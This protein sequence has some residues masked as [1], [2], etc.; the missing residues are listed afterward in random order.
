MKNCIVC[1]APLPLRRQKL[2]S[3]QCHNKRVMASEA[4]RKAKAKSESSPAAKARKRAREEAAKVLRCCE[5]CGQAWKVK[6]SRPSRYCSP[7]CARAAQLP[8]PRCSIPPGHPALRYPL[9]LPPGKTRGPS[10]CGP[11]KQQDRARSRYT[12]A[13]CRWCRSS[14][15]AIGAY[16]QVYCSRACA[17]SYWKALRRAWLR[18]VECETISRVAV[19]ERDGWTCYLCRQP[20][21]RGAQPP[22]DPLAPTLD[23]VQPLARGGAHTMSNLRTAHFLCNSRKGIGDADANLLALA[24]GG[25]SE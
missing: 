1:G 24:A 17:R 20:V 5:W 16:T 22:Y 7:R 6:R 9:A 13:R 10:G 11:S 18:Q 12:S 3:T 23:H 19:F 15:I 8:S 21:K 14:F 2:C 25:G 4:W